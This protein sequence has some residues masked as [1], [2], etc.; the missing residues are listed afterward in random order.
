MNLNR[1]EHAEFTTASFTR[2]VW[3]KNLVIFVKASK[4]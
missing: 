3:D 1:Y 4:T 2:G